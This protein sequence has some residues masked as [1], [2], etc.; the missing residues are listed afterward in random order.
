MTIGWPDQSV[1][2]RAGTA[3]LVALCAARTIHLTSRSAVDRHRWRWHL[4]T[5][6]FIIWAI[7]WTTA[8]M[9]APSDAAMPFLSLIGLFRQVLFLIALLP[10]SGEDQGWRLRSL[11]VAQVVLL[12]VL[13]AILSWPGTALLHIRQ[14]DS[15]F[16]YVG[17]VALAVVAIASYLRQSGEIRRLI[18]PLAILHS[19]YAVTSIFAAVAVAKWG[20][21]DNSAKWVFGDMAFVAYLWATSKKRCETSSRWRVLILRVPRDLPPLLLA[22]VILML[23]VELGRRSLPWGMGV[24]II[25]LIIYVTRT[26]ILNDRYLTL[27]DQLIATEEARGR[28][29]IDIVHEIRSPLGS[30]ALNAALL[31]KGDAI[32]QPQRRW[33]EQIEINTT[34]VTTLLNDVLE[35]ERLDA[36]LIDLD[37]QPCGPEAVI[38]AALAVVSAQAIEFDITLTVVPCSTTAPMMADPCKLSRVLINL[39]GNAIRF[40]PA[41]GRV[42]ISTDE[43]STKYLAITVEDTGI[44]I[45]PEAQGLLFKRFGY[46]ATPVNGRRGSGLGLSI[47]AGIIRAMGGT[48]SLESIATVGTK[49]EIV[50][51]VHAAAA[52]S[53][54]YR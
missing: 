50:M 8:A 49:A 10:T 33:V 17:H 30:V 28:A 41:G 16:L 39:I 52:T 9:M 43:R 3:A 38:A 29:L 42:T 4:V 40:T 46:C 15:R 34:Q 35:L 20:F 7:S 21:A 2:M 19:V 11:D 48:L 47:S 25:G 53:G 51:P 13:L 54:A 14:T 22:A 32:P 5:A 31:T 12:G 24:G 44:G 27:R 36:G 18:G 1:S 23:S 37:I 45:P 6:A 26:T